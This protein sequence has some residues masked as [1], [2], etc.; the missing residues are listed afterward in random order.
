MEIIDIHL[1]SIDSTNA[2]AKR[3][4]GSFLPNHITCITADEQSAGYGRNQRN[5]VSPNSNNLYATFCFQLPFP[6]HHLSCLTYVCACS[7]A[8]LLIDDGL[9]PQIKWPN[10][11]LLNQK[12]LAGILCETEFEKK[13]VKIILGVGVNLNMKQADLDQINQPA[14]SLQIEA[15]HPID[16]NQFLL[17]LQKRFTR[18]LE[19]FKKDG[20]SPFYDKVNQLLAYKGTTIH[21][22]DGQKRWTGICHSIAIDGRL[23]LLLPTGQIH[24]LLSGELTQ[25]V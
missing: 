12:K 24:S 13:W 8:A 6:C 9:Q 11:I 10:D 3:E 23:N 25:E 7:L 2:Y 21:C 17:R 5:W 1:T 16:R 22:F 20:F 14:T 19:R 15:G 18:E 4:F